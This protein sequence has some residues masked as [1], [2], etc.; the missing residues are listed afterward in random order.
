LFAQSSQRFVFQ[1][2]EQLGDE[3][4][5]IGVQDTPQSVFEVLPAVAELSPQRLAATR[6]AS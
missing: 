2:G 4:K 6:R 1:V 5:L 3:L